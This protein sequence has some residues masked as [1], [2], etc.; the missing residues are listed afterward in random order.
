MVG[1]ALLFS[2]VANARGLYNDEIAM[3]HDLPAGAVFGAWLQT[4]G[5]M[6]LLPFLVDIASPGIVGVVFGDLNAT[7]SERNGLILLL[8][9]APALVLVTRT[10]L[11]ALC[12]HTGLRARAASR[13]LIFGSDNEARRLASTLARNEAAGMAIVGFI[14]MPGQAAPAMLDGLPVLVLDDAASAGVERLHADC[15]LLSWR[16]SQGVALEEVTRLLAPLPIALKLVPDLA[17]HGMPMQQIDTRSQVPMVVICA[18]PPPIWART[19]KRIED[20]I[21][22]PLLLLLLMPV[23]IATAIAIKLDSPGPIFF[24]QRRVGVG[25]RQFTMLKFRTMYHDCA[26]AAGCVQTTRNDP[27]VT[28]VGAIL[29]RLNIDELPQLVNVIFGDMSLVGPRPHALQTHVGGL[30]FEQAVAIYSARHRIRPGM[31]GWAQVNG[32]R[33]ET[34]TLEKLQRR[35]EHDLWY[36]HNSTIGLDLLILIRTILAMARGRNAY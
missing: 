11:M 32:W 1:L 31:T 26:D 33:G 27:R 15:V 21:L 29:R 12:R 5:L 6:A 14:V 18:P 9:L 2:F 4:C 23:L 17:L 28:R 35:V 24:L 22:A 19:L 8:F 36:I 30:R 13:A 7:L 16:M 20:L 34:D 10:G 3:F 25:E